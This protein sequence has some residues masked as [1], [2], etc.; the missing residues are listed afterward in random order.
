MKLNP[1]GLL[2]YW[3]FINK[4]IFSISISSWR[5]NTIESEYK[6]IGLLD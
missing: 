6:A 4:S 2:T 1:K 5:L 3:K